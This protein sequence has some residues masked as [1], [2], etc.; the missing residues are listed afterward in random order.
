MAKRRLFSVS[1]Q[2]VYSAGVGLERPSVLPVIQ[3]AVMLTHLTDVLS[4]ILG[5][6]LYARAQSTFK[7]SARSKVQ[8]A[9]LDVEHGMIVNPKPP[10]ATF[11][12]PEL[13][14]R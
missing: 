2:S 3:D 14:E 7:K 4:N 5:I 8:V 1:T 11:F 6:T 9:G 12:R 13:D 10:V